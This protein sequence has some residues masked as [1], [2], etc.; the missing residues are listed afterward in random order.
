MADKEKA[1][2][3]FLYFV[4]LGERRL[5]DR[6]KTE[7]LDFKKLEGFAALYQRDSLE[8]LINALFD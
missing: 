3:D 5:N 8:E 6:M 1:V 7:G 4:S 2:V